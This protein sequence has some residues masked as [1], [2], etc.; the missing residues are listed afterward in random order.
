MLNAYRQ[1]F[2]HRLRQREIVPELKNYEKRTELLCNM[3]L[4]RAKKLKEPAYTEEEYLKKNLKAKKACGRDLFPPEIFIRGGGR[5]DKLLLSMFEN[6]KNGEIIPH[7]WT[8]VLISTLYKNKGKRKQLV[9]YRGIFL[10]QILSKMFGKLNMNRIT[11]NVDKINKFQAGGKS[12][13][14]LHT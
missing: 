6:I 8:Q 1:E 13:S 11:D 5:L 12:N 7:Q 4:E 14:L 9:N 10:K 2:T 3:Y